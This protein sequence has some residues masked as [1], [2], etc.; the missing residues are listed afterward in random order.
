MPFK[1]RQRPSTAAKK[2]S[3]ARQG[4]MIKTTKKGAYAPARKKAMINRRAPTVE[5]WQTVAGNWGPWF[6]HSRGSK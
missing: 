2:A 5:T 1:S 6:G 3:L 4:A